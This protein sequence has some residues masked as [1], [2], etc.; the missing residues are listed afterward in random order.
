MKYETHDQIS[1][2][3][4]V[5]PLDASEALASVE[6]SYDRHDPYA[7]TIVFEVAPGSHRTWLSARDLLLDGLLTPTGDGDVRMRPAPHDPELVQV[8]LHST[9]GKA[10]L[11]ASVRDIADF[12]DA[13]YVLVPPGQESQWFDFDAELRRITNVS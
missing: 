2:T 3:V 9:A 13:T 6:M 12:I 11:E 10:R 4:Q 5:L 8:E 1:H 7:V